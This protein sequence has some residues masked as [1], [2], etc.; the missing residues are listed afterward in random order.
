MIPFLDP[1]LRL[2][3][4]ALELWNKWFGA[5][6]KPTAEEARRQ[7]AEVMAQMEFNKLAALAQKGDKDAQEE[8]RRRL[9]NPGGAGGK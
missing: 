3:A 7:K 9:A 5:Y 8:L 4:G 1:L 2:G 6:T